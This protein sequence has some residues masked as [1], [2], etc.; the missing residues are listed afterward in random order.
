MKNQINEEI[1]NTSMLKLLIHEKYDG[2]VKLAEDNDK[3][4]SSIRHSANDISILIPIR[5]KIEDAI[6]DSLL[7]INNE[8]QDF[9]R[10]QL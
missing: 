3:L 4:Y 10:E 2:I 5:K 1:N 7:K 6:A 8:I 9:L